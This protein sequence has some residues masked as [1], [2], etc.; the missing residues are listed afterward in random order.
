MNG[1]TGNFLHLYFEDR[2]S[3][4]NSNLKHDIFNEAVRK[5]QA[6][7]RLE[8]VEESEERKETEEN[9]ENH[10]TPEINESDEM[11]EIEEEI[12]VYLNNVNENSFNCINTYLVQYPLRPKYRPYNYTST[13]QNIYYGTNYN[14]YRRIK[15]NQGKT[16]ECFVFEYKLHEYIKE[17]LHKTNV[18][19][20]DSVSK[21]ATD[22]QQTYNANIG[23]LISS[24]VL[25]DYISSCV[26]YFKY[27]P[28]T[29]NREIYLIPVKDI[30]QF[31]PTFDNIDKEL[32]N[33]P[34]SVP[35]HENY[36]QRSSQ[37]GET[38]QDYENEKDASFFKTQEN[39][40]LAS[41][42]KGKGETD[43]N[44]KFGKNKWENIYNI[45]DA[46]SVEAHEI[47]SLFTNVRRTNSVINFQHKERKDTK[48]NEQKEEFPYMK[49]DPDG[50][51]YLNTICRDLEET[52]SDINTTTYVDNRNTMSTKIAPISSLDFGNID[53]KE[54]YKT[55]SNK[56]EDI[57]YGNINRFYFLSLSLDEQVIE[58]LRLK[59]VQTLDEIKR[60]LKYNENEGLLIDTLK[61]YCVNILGSWVIKSKYL[62]K[63]DKETTEKKEKVSNDKFTFID[64]KILVRNL[65]IG[66]IYKQVEPL[67]IQFIE[68]EKQ[69][70]KKEVHGEN[71]EQG[72][73]NNNNNNTENKSNNICDK[74]ITKKINYS[75]SI[76][77]ENFEKATNLPNH[78]IL[79]IFTPLCEYK[80]TGY[81]YKYWIDEDF[82]R[83]HI[84]ICL[85]YHQEWKN[86]LTEIAKLIQHFKTKSNI[87][88][89]FHIDKPTIEKHII[90]ILNNNCFP[91]STI[92][93]KL[94]K[95]VKNVPID[96]NIF[97][98][99]L[100]SVAVNINNFWCL[101]I[102]Q[103]NE[104]N[105][106]RNALIQT[107]QQ[108]YNLVSTKTQLIA[109][110]EKRL[111][112]PLNIPD[113][114]FRNILK[115]LCIQR[116]GRYWFKGNDHLNET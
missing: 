77:I 44:R 26:G 71:K 70:L 53:K 114:Y 23:R 106:C 67:I 110:V 43:E 108:N 105:N 31:K 76:L 36:L 69:K 40:E 96:M 22:M 56:N 75:N 65:L 6:S 103:E 83:K 82:L 20:R 4:S 24:S 13:L 49:F 16:E 59:N 46:D 52:G 7:E 90:R 78:I 116:E 33:E 93:E 5:M 25:C 86:K 84:K 97:K 29:K 55:S 68:T 47:I 54:N 80:H 1:T 8:D 115:E 100:A 66:L 9:N 34:E 91:L 85:L 14:K 2:V 95:E 10:R 112:S 60:I 32:K 28:E 37:S 87:I 11:D 51:S 58:I 48:G 17:D 3:L 21:S 42:E 72:C 92:H 98:Q 73:K 102:V 104:I 19:I 81:Y 63:F 99:A 15:N 111:K 27:N 41:N 35:T 18:T 50:V 30:Y 38:K 89:D 45:Y 88:N 64:Y 62:Y 101:N 61:K 109:E 39:E 12:D 107:Y 113:I 94:K 74:N 57:I 79:D